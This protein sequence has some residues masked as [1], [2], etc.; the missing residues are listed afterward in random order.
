MGRRQVAPTVQLCLLASFNPPCPSN[1][2]TP[3]TA[4]EPRF[5][6][7]KPCQLAAE[8][9]EG[10]KKEKKKKKLSLSFPCTTTTL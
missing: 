3:Y 4:V 10:G 2:G 8:R 6:A 5:D 7:F 1:I 9:E